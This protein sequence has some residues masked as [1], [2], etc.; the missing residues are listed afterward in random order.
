MGKQDAPCDR[1]IW[2]AVRFVGSFRSGLVIINW[3]NKGSFVIKVFTHFYHFLD[4]ISGDHGLLVSVS[5]YA[6]AVC[7]DDRN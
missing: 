3:W 4:I 1:V 5:L 7:H 2:R 6:T